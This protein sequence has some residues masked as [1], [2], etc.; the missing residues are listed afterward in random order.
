MLPGYKTAV[1][2]WQNSMFINADIVVT[3]RPL[4][5]DSGMVQ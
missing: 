5:L 3:P 4:H 1:L 2:F